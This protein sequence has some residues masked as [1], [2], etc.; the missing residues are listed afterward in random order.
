MADAEAQSVIRGDRRTDDRSSQA[1]SLRFLQLLAA[2]S[3]TH[4]YYGT[5]ADPGEASEDP[6]TS[7]AKRH[8]VIFTSRLNSLCNDLGGS[9]AIAAMYTDFRLRKPRVIAVTAQLR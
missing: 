2:C 4:P 3:W 1:F 7:T 6:G 5:F 9:L 8:I